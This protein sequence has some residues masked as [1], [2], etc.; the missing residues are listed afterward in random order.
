VRDTEWTYEDG[1]DYVVLTDPHGSPFCI[2]QT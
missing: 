1:A 2:V